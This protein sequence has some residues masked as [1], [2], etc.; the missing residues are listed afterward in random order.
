MTNRSPFDSKNPLFKGLN[1]KQLAALDSISTDIALKT[2]EYLMKEGEPGS[3]MYIV[4]EGSLEVIKHDMV[5]GLIHVIG[6]LHHGDTVGDISFLDHGP[7][8][9]SVRA[10]G[11]VRLK[12]IPFAALEQLSNSDMH[13]THS[14]I[15]HLSQNITR[16]L[17]RTNIRVV[18]ALHHQVEEYKTRIQMGQFLVYIVVILAL[19]LYSFRFLGFELKQAGTTTYV[20]TPIIIFLTFFVFLMIW[21]SELPLEVFGLTLKN[22]KRSVVEGLLMT[23]PICVLALVVKYLL[24]EFTNLYENR[25]L[26]DLFSLTSDPNY[27]TLTYWALVNFFYALFVPVQELMARGSLQGLLERFFIGKWKVITSII[28]SNLIFS[29]CH[30]FVSDWM[31]IVALI[32]GLFFGMLYARTHNLI[33]VIICHILVGVWALGILG[34]VIK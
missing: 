1:Q 5:N 22:W 23:I 21:S 29:T 19:L 34:I 18:E 11:D 28:V 30:A 25:P 3:E 4:L 14:L 26:F 24:M 9:A 16:I 27:H 10:L 32:G 8:S 31:A 13:L 17:R 15:K 7:R 12:R 6:N 33:G 20:S 2:G